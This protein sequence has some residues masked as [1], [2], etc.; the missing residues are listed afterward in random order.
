MRGIL[1]ASKW[2]LILLFFLFNCN[3]HMFMRG[4]LAA[5]RWGLISFLYFFTSSEQSLIWFS[6]VSQMKLASQGRSCITTSS[7]WLLSHWIAMDDFDHFFLLPTTQSVYLN[8][9]ALYYPECSAECNMMPATVSFSLLLSPIYDRNQSLSV[10]LKLL[11]KITWIIW[12]LIHLKRNPVIWPNG[13]VDH[14][15]PVFPNGVATETWNRRSY[16]KRYLR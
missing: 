6:I 15:H 13:Y 11:C 4:I 9:K 12:W 5:S 2:G 3:Q 10:K 1:A 14:S 7:Q 8:P 16:N